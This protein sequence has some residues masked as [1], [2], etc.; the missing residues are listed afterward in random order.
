M[1]R[2][3][4]LY[5]NNKPAIVAESCVSVELGQDYTLSQ[6]V[7]ENGA[8]E[9][10]DKVW[11]PY[12]IRMRLAQGQSDKDRTAFLNSLESLAG[13]TN[14]YQAVTPEKTYPS[15]NVSHYS[16]RREASNGVSLIVAELWLTQIMQNVTPQYLNVR[17][18]AVAAPVSG[19]NVQTAAVTNQQ[20]MSVQSSPD[21]T[22]PATVG[23][24]NY[25]M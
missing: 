16:Y 18:P 25:Q 2:T 12:T 22:N 4:G 13:D 11:I 19:G 1:A 10:Y 9:S 5:I 3:W 23:F 17:S 24:D 15:V 20:E 6:Y 14:I 7:L 21:L 8:F